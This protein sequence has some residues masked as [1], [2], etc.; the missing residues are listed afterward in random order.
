MNRIIFVTQPDIIDGTAYALKNYTN[1]DIKK[2][3][4]DCD[5]TVIFYLIEEDCQPKWLNS[6]IKQSKI[7]FDCSQSSTQNIIKNVR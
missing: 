7:I 1:E 3:L 2:I 4:N 5:K 6:V